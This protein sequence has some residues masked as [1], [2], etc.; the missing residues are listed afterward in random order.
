MGRKSGAERW[1]QVLEEVVKVKT[2][3]CKET[4][5]TSVQPQ[6]Y[7]MCDSVRLVVATAIFSIQLMFIY[8]FAV[9]SPKLLAKPF[10]SAPLSSALHMQYHSSGFARLWVIAVA[11]TAN[12]LR[13]LRVTYVVAILVVRRAKQNV[14]A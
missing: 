3:G 4:R 10:F 5:T 11:V 12:A 7:R 14:L 6:E 2:G 13:Q 8:L 9:S 1:L